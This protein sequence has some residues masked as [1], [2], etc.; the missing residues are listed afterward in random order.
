MGILKYF[1]ITHYDKLHRKSVPSSSKTPSPSVSPSSP[2]SSKKKKEKQRFSCPKC[3]IPFYSKFS[4][5]RHISR[6]HGEE[7]HLYRESDF[8]LKCPICQAPFVTRAFLRDHVQKHSGVPGYLCSQCGKGFFTEDNLN[9]HAK[10]HC[11]KSKTTSTARNRRQK[12]K[13]K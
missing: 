10:K 1:Q 13:K 3:T 8:R 5:N 9:Q 6:I 4:L 12:R 11:L 7:P 2:N